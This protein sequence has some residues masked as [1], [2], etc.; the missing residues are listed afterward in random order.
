MMWPHTPLFLLTP[1]SECCECSPCL[2]PPGTYSLCAFVHAHPP[3]PRTLP[4]YNSH[5]AFRSQ[6]K[7]CFLKE[8]HHDAKTRINLIFGIITLI[9][10][11]WDCMQEVCLSTW[12]WVMQSRVPAYFPQCCISRTQK[13]AST[14]SMHLPTHLSIH[15]PIHPSLH[16]SIH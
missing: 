2:E 14:I 8:A 1:T 11:N 3:L 12:L 10:H 9:R 16:P 4:L 5:S 6:N 7:Q 13:T 15:L